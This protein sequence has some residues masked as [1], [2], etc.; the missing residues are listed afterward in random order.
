[1]LI[2]LA[3]LF[4]GYAVATPARFEARS[5]DWPRMSSCARERRLSMRAR[6][7]RTISAKVLPLERS[8][9][10]KG[11]LGGSAEGRTDFGALGA[12]GLGDLIVGLLGGTGDLTAG[13]VKGAPGFDDLAPE[14]GVNARG[15]ADAARAA[16]ASEHATRMKTTRIG[17]RNVR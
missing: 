5:D 2:T 17:E 12:E 9:G 16:G 7:S 11:V 10:E 13:L 6:S 3:I 8:V 15:T 4:V 14:A 1:M